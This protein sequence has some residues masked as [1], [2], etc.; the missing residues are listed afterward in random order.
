MTATSE[1]PRGGCG[2]PWM[3]PGMAHNMKG[4]NPDR[5]SP[6]STRLHWTDYGARV[7]TAA[8]TAYV[9]LRICGV[10]S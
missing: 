6:A 4:L 2:N 5:L 10:W 8:A 9:T 1:Q 7:I 3:G